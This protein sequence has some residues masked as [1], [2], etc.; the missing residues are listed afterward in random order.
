MKYLVIAALFGL[1]EA[2]SL[3]RPYDAEYAEF[4]PNPKQSPWAAKKGEETTS[5]ISKGWWAYQDGL[6]DYNRVVT[7]QH[8]E[9][10]SDRLMWSLIKQYAIEGN[11]GDKPNGH[12]YLGKKQMERVS[13]EVIGT[14]FGWKGKKRDKYMKEKFD[15]L[16]KHFD[17]MNE[18]FVDVDKG[19]VF[20]K[21]LLGDVEINQ[22][23][24]VQ[25][26]EGHHHSHPVEMIDIDMR[27]NP[28]Q[29]PWAAK[30][31]E[32][33]PKTKVDD[34]FIAGMSG[35]A[36]YDRQIP[37]RFSEKSDDQ[38]MKSLIKTYSV[39]G[40]TDGKPNG[41][42]YLTK[43]GMDKVA[44]EVVG[45]HFGFK[46][47][48]R[49]DYL[50]KQ[51]PKLWKAADVNKDG[52][53]EVARAPMVLR[54]L[55]DN[56]EIG[57]GLQ[58]ALGE[59]NMFLPPQVLGEVEYRPNPDQAPWSV[60]KE[61]P[62]K[63]T[64]ITDAFHPHQHEVNGYI[65]AAPE[66]FSA[67]SDDR[68]MN[69]LITTYS[70]EGNTNGKPNGHFYMTKT[71]LHSAAEEVTGTHLGLKDAAKRAYVQ[72]KMDELWGKYDPNND[73]FI[74]TERAATFLRQVVGEV[75][76]SFGL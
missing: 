64:K 35:S 59:D 24:M 10:G 8:D 70:L 41:Q 63:T 3:S 23:L 76:A 25:L 50:A 7:P 28:T 17:V 16:W 38:L 21:S 60:A 71:A 14:H 26:N 37:E 39:E 67:E 57:N 68:L 12:F 42:F 27:P 45:T 56:Q 19:P 54:T 46:G 47:K 72:Q 1:T 15:K 4:R 75:E 36:Y 22:G 2:V 34:A 13:R 29:S 52:F 55:L 32:G 51:L 33:P 49:D 62:P 31:V 5:K 48:K 66:H 69:S 53:I 6:A 74:E 43:K 30:K 58:V 61:D 40:N 65:R 20:L 9:K 18:G 11:T 73:G 44:K